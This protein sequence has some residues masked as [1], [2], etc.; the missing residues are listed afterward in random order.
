MRLSRVPYVALALFVAGIALSALFA[1]PHNALSQSG[2]ASLTGYA[3]SDT[4]GWISFSG[5]NYGITVDNNGKLSGYAWS[6]NI[7]W[8]SANDADLAGCPSNPCTAKFNNS[9]LNG[10]M[11]ALAGGS[12][13]SGGWDGW[14]SLS[15]SGYGVT[16]SSVGVVSGFAWG[17]TVVGWVDFSYAAPLSPSCTLS[18]A[19]QSIVKG[20]TA[21]LSWVSSNATS[22]TIDPGGMTATPVAGG[23][24]GVQPTATT[25]YTGSFTG[26]GGTSLCTAIVNVQCAPLYSCSG[27]NII[28]TNAA[29]ANTTVSTCIAPSYCEAGQ[30]TCQWPPI[31]VVD[32]GWSNGVDGHLTAQ[33]QIIK[34]GDKTKLY[35]NVDN[36]QS[37]TVS[38]NENGVVRTWSG[39]TSGPGGAQTSVLQQ[40]TTY[41]LHCVAYE[42]NEDL[43]ESVDVLVTPKFKER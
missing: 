24:I 2:S 19:T 40:K 16:K 26:A 1:Q 9:Q 31:I 42:G 20:N 22:G 38:G 30:T 11:K 29:C 14:I 18:P 27:A 41:T 39:K 17:S 25:T 37:C 3:W 10:W 21:S 32:P 7:G 35:W 6:D 5:S 43:D 33:P 13:G 36:V 8:I 28:Y 4:I 15:G 23:T 12:S 34:A